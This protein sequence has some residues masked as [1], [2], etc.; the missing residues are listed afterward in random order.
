MCKLSYTVVGLSE[1][2]LTMPIARF[3]SVKAKQLIYYVKGFW[4]GDIPYNEINLFIWDTLEEWKQLEHPSKSPVSD[5][6][7]VFW[8]IVFQFHAGTARVLKNNLSLKHEMAV[9]IDFLEN[10]GLKPF[11]CVGIRP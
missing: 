10:G 3:V 11:Y 4:N 2:A 6:E 9:C 7:Q 1:K 8:H 5:R